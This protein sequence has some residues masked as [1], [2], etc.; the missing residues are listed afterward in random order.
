[1][2]ISWGTLDVNGNSLTFHQLKA[3]DYG[4]V[5]ANNVDK[6]ATITLDYAL[7][8]D[9][10]ALNGWSESGKGTA[11]NLYKYNNPYTNTTDYFILKQSTYGYF[12][13]DQSS[14]ATGSLWGT[15]R[16]CTETGS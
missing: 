6:R 16:G 4:A 9:K 10:V 15:V 7:R 14:N 1:M 8:A 2:G 11:G 13:T 3:A 12:P 5:L